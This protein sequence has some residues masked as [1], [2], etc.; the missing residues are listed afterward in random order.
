M[1]Y[2]HC[3]RYQGVVR[4]I[5][6]MTLEEMQ[7]YQGR[8]KVPENFDEF[9]DKQLEKLK[10]PPKFSLQKKQFQ[11]KNINCYELLFDGTNHSK[12]FAKLL[13]PIKKKPVPL[14][15]CF[16]GY[17]GRSADWSEFFK[18]TMLGYGVVALDVRGQ[19]GHSE[20]HGEFNGVTVKGQ[21]IR[22]M[23]E[24]PEHLFFKDIFLDLYSLI[25]IV[26]SL[27]EVDE[28]NLQTFGGSQGGALALVSAALN[29]RIKQV[30]TIYPFLSD[31]PRI[32]EVG[33]M[34]EPYDEL[35]RYFKFVDPMYKTKNQIMETLDY[36]DMKNFA[37]R[38]DCPVK[39]ITG[40]R[41]EICLPSTQFAI[42]NRLNHNVQHVILPEYGHEAMNVGVSDLTTNWLA[43]IKID[44]V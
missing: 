34:T 24:G 5:E 36:I 43:K 27:P 28:T 29:K 13:L 6:T 9:W 17:H 7:S 18:Y 8:R 35:F 30:V 11:I 23:T 19:A 2:Y 33:Q 15:F 1:L 44:E 26:A 25:E 39:M 14:L 42:A 12:I 37:H 16:H 20:D 31:F 38:I 21:V 22:G 41:D 32:L 4:V 10:N 3:K 40:L